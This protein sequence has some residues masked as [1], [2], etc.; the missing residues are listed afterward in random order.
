V[1]SPRLSIIPLLQTW[2]AQSGELRV[3]V[4]VLPDA[5]PR[6]PLSDGWPMPVPTAPAFE[7]AQIVL[8]A[9]L[10][11]DPALLPTRADVPTVGDPFLLALPTAQA[12]I[13]DELEVRFRIVLPPVPLTRS[14]ATRLGKYLPE[15]YRGAFAFV[16]PKTPLAFTDDTY[17]RALRCRPTVPRPPARPPGEV[18]WPEALAFALRHPLLAR[19]LGLVHTVTVP[20]AGAFAAGGW[21][22]FALDDTSAFA[23]QAAADAGFVRAFATRVPPLKPGQARAVFTPTVF[24]V[25]VDASGVAAFGNVDHALYEA[26][27]YDDGFARIVHASQPRTADPIEE[28]EDGPPPLLDVGMALGWDDEDVL[29]AQNRAMGVEPDDSMPGGAPQVVLGYRVDVA[30]DADPTWRSLCRVRA[31]GVAFGPVALGDLEWEQ[32]YEVHPRQINDRFFLPIMFAR[33]RGRSLVA[34]TREDRLLAG[35]ATATSTPDEPVGLEEVRLQ[36]GRQYRVRVRLADLSGGGS[37]PST[38]PDTPTSTQVARW[39][40]RRYVAPG[41]PTVVT[42]GTA[43]RP[44]TYAVRRPSLGY[45]EATYT[46]I[47][48]ARD[49]LIAQMEASLAGGPERRPEL[50]DPDVEA[51]EIAVRV[52]MP[53]F[54]PSADPDG[55]RQLY[56][57]YRAFRADPAAPAPLQLRVIDAARLSDHVWEAMPAFPGP[58]EGPI[59]VP[60]NRDV[61]VLVRCVTRDDA[62]YF[63]NAAARRGPWR[64]LSTTPIRAAATAEPP[65]FAPTSPLEALASVFLQ[66]DAPTTSSNGD[67]ALQ[68]KPSPKLAARLAAPSACW[69]TVG[70]CWP[71]PGGGSSSAARA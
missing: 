47:G 67:A 31:R 59:E 40:F 25:A 6:R 46:G 30:T 37:A 21:L 9:A 54:D 28:G 39:R 71:N 41:P 15:S 43:T 53:A 35:I 56:A 45:P 68:T 16:A 70:R 62:N 24:P 2:D 5:D 36:W 19:A 10:P 60:S 69:R 18:S 26:A 17:H 48:D 50:P 63:G 34:M 11:G 22:Y 42:I 66:P 55:Y 44:T 8:R 27:A 38:D 57:A 1:T 29:L 14:P 3:N 65:V 33:W 12:A 64:E 4:V 32:P 7:G 51:I 13:L 49:Q 52:R 58:G 23:A 61:R 20:A